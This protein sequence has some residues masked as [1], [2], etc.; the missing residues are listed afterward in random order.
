[1][2][3]NAICFLVVLSFNSATMAEIEDVIKL[4]PLSDFT[5]F[6]KGG[7]DLTEISYFANRGGT[8]ITL[9]GMYTLENGRNEKEKEI[10]KTFLDAGEKM[11]E[12]GYEM[13]LKVNH[14]SVEL[15]IEQRKLFTKYYSDKIK[16]AKLLNNDIFSDDNVASDF[17]LVVDNFSFIEG[18]RKSLI[19][20]SVDM[21]N[22]TSNKIIPDTDRKF[23]K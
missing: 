20:D 14:R 21:K 10:G 15:I 17:K 13:D 7:E 3:I 23:K 12:Y 22:S 2:K 8:L 18:L 11:L 4:N 16:K 5:E 19:E 6:I 9:V 1:M